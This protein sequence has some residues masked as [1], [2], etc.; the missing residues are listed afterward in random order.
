[1][2]HR[3]NPQRFFSK[4]KLNPDTGCMEWPGETYERGY[5]KMYST[6]GKFRA[7]RVAAYLA[8]MID[9]PRGAQSGLDGKNVLHTCD[10]PSCC[11][12]EHLFIGTHADNVA[13]MIA[14]GR[15]KMPPAGEFVGPRRPPHYAKK[16]RTSRVMGRPRKY[17]DAQ[18]E[19]IKMLVGAGIYSQGEM[20][21]K[22]GTSQGW[23][24]LVMSGKVRKP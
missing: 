14:K 19:E 9:T 12:P 4:L 17:S 6:A 11:N 21:K 5:G 8:G 23:V 1:M 10:N 2:P 22:L 24:S 7:H 18:I 3:I 13:D 16:D 20:A 15:A